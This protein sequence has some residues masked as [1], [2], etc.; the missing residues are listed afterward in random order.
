MGKFFLFIRK[1]HIYILFVI[2]EVIAI[3]YYRNSSM[4]A[5]ATVLM[6]SKSVTMGVDKVTGEISS[7]INLREENRLLSEHV[8]QLSAE[9]DSYRLTLKGI[10]PDSVALSEEI[11]KGR[12]DY[13]PVNVVGNSIVKLHNF[14]TIDK[15]SNQGIEDKMA[16]VSGGNILGYVVAIS[17]NFALAIS[18]LNIDFKSSGK[19]KGTEFYGSILWDGV[20]SE[21]VILTE[22]PKYADINVGDTITST[23]YSSIFPPDL[24]IG[25]V[26]SFELINGTYFTAKVRLS[27]PMGKIDNVIAVK[28]LDSAERQMLIDDNQLTN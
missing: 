20:S 24:N 2:F 17:D 6:H 25:I 8:A 28:Y 1:I 11:I 3:G 15:G 12:Y 18:I 4:Y 19:I 10:I 23:T 27:Q 21:E 26:E 9:L 22:L 7:F 5:D 13:T 14:I 16:L